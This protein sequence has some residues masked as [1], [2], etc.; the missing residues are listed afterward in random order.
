MDEKNGCDDTDNVEISK[1]TLL[2]CQDIAS[3]QV[4]P[5]SLKEVFVSVVRFVERRDSSLPMT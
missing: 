4:V 1:S 5:D 3:Q 2:H